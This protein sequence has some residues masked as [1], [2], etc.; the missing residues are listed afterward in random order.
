M[1]RSSDNFTDLKKKSVAP[2]VYQLPNGL[3]IQ[4]LNQ[5]ETNFVYGEIFNDLDLIINASM[6][7][8]RRVPEGASLIQRQLGLNESGIPCITLI[9][10]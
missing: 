1:I 2:K 6:S 9:Q 8:E 7:F 5:H 4:H 10:A 3:K